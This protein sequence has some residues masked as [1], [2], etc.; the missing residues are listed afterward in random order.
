MTIRNLDFMFKPKSIALI[1][2]SASQCSVGHTLARNLLDGQFTGDI[3]LVNPK[4]RQL[5]GHKAYSSLKKIPAVPE[6]AVIAT[7]PRSISGLIDELGQLGTRAVVLISA[8]F[9][10]SVSVGEELQLAALEA[11]RPYLLRVLGPSCLDG[12][13]HLS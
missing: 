13:W 12:T 1:G 10:E 11:A 5:L 6:L 8:S 4:H 9:A 3:W 2:A 7:P